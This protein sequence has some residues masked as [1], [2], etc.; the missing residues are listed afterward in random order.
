MKEFDL[1][2]R[3]L[4]PLA[5]PGGLE[6]SDD[7]AL[8]D[9]PAGE[10]LV[11]TKDIMVEGRHWLPQTDPADLGA[12]LLAVNLS[13]LAAMGAAPL[14]YL[15]GLTLPAPVDEAWLAGLTRGLRAMQDAHAIPLIGGDTT[16][17]ADKAVLSVT[18]LGR[19][20][21]PIRRNRA[22]PG[23]RLY[24]S[25]TLGDAV[26]G[27]A[28]ARGERP[29]DPHCLARH[30]RPEPRLALGRAVRHHATAAIDLSDGLMADAGHI[31]AASGVR[32]VMEAARLPFSPPVRAALAESPSLL[33]DLVTG[34]DDYE[35]LISSADALPQSLAQTALTPIGWVEAG[36]GVAL[37]DERGS[38]L[39]LSS[40]GF[41]HFQER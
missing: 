6:L 1:I 10:R 36:A 25:G 28:M 40:G 8:I 13:D 33:M 14:G 11:I 37:I 22:A 27:L 15:L 34:G 30:D 29:A 12:K 38:E 5:G 20:E 32:L 2:A 9:P 23:D 31:A 41:D 35:L 26:L 18:A 19:T 16:G 24:L 7:A 39:T 21:T 17:G 4:A 3:Y